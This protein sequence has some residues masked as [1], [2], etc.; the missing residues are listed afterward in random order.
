MTLFTLKYAPRNTSEIIGQGIAVA[1]LRDFILNYK[2]QK[3]RA[4]LLYGPIGCGKTSSVYALAKELNYDIV[5]MNSSDVRNE[6]NITSFLNSALVQQS[7]FFR[8]KIVLLD[9]IDN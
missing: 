6:E 1:Q 7:L 8:P 5:E 9:E 4:A 2:Q 3:Q